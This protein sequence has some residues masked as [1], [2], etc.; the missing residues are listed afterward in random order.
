MKE[1]SYDLR[2]LDFKE[3]AYKWVMREKDKPHAFRTIRRKDTSYNI[4]PYCIDREGN[5]V[6]FD[7][8][9]QSY[10][11]LEKGVE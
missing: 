9:E 6:F 3:V 8:I 10:Y 5:E 2:K 7:A 1:N 4:H 11:L